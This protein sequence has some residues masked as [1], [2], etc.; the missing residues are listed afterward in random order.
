MTREQQKG[1]DFYYCLPHKPRERRMM[2]D[3]KWWT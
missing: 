1:E 3:S 2:T